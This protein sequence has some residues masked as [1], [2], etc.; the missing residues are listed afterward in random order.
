M[1]EPWPT[2][3]LGN[4]YYALPGIAFVACLELEIGQWDKVRARVPNKW[5]RGW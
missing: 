4:A 1:N 2:L 3:F 5:Q